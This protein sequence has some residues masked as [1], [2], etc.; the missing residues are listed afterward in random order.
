MKKIL[1]AFGGNAMSPP[2]RKRSAAWRL[3]NIEKVVGQL[4]PLLKTHRILLTHGNGCDVGN[5]ILQQ[6]RGAKLVPSKPLDTLN[7]MT[8]GQL[9]YWLQQAVLNQLGITAAVVL[10][11]ILVDPKDPDF[12]K[13]TKQVG[14]FYKRRCFAN[15]VYIRGMGYR[16]AVASPKPGKV[17]ETD[18]IIKLFKERE[19]VIAG[20]GGGIPVVRKAGRYVGVDAVIDKDRTSAKLAKL[21]KADTLLILTNVDGA[22]LNFGS[23]HRKHLDRLST[24]EAARYLNNGEFGVGSMGPKIEAGIEFVRGGGKCCRIGHWEKLQSVLKGKSGTMI[25][26]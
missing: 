11:R 15:M 9:G 4:K 12:K 10:T 18:L 13:K 16:R 6:E 7:A 17:L 22:Y 23:H 21:V 25:E 14:S 24:K 5:L 8:Q 1:I 19:L 3:K 20:G 2:D 26:P